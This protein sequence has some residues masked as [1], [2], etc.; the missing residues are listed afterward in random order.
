MI[1]VQVYHQH[2]FSGNLSE[3]P[4]WKEPEFSSPGYVFLVIYYRRSGAGD[5]RVPRRVV[6]MGISRETAHEEAER[7]ARRHDPSPMFVRV[8]DPEHPARYK[9]S[10]AAGA[11]E[12]A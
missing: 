3:E 11:S 7:S 1:W 4:L 6:G 9:G 12:D 10:Q 8:R 5:N 2:L